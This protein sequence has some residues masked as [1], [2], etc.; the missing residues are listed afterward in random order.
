VKRMRLLREPEYL[1]RP[2]NIF[3]RVALRALWR[4][5]RVPVR[6]VAGPVLM[7]REGEFIGNHLINTRCHDPALS[8]LLWRMIRPG[9]LCVDVGANIGYI[10]LLMASRCGP[11]GRCLSYE[12]D[13][14]I[15][16]EL[17]SNTAGNHF[18]SIVEAHQVAVSSAAGILRF[19]RALGANA[20]LG[21]VCDETASA[22]MVEVRAAC[23]DDWLQSRGLVRVLKMDVE[24]HELPALQGMQNALERRQVEH[25]FFEDHQGLDSE[26]A[27]FLRNHGFK[28]FSLQKELRGPALKPCDEAIAGD[29]EPNFLATLNPSEAQACARPRGWNVL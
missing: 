8:E 2:G 16:E 25:L 14:G 11:E 17:K 21:R 24:G 26:V 7:A 12:A 4:G 29:L 23:L 13:P 28:V 6:T 10:T 15:F 18:D 20:G 1:L 27:R 5:K 22:E 19:K 3:R 9:D